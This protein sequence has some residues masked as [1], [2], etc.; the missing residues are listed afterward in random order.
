MSE[1]EVRF[2]LLGS[3]P[4]ADSVF[5]GE[6][7]QASVRQ[8]VRALNVS[9]RP[10]FDVMFLRDAPKMGRISFSHDEVVSLE[11]QNY[12]YHV[13]DLEV[14]CDASYVA[15]GVVVSNCRSSSTPVL[16]SYRELGIPIDEISASTRASMDGEVPAETTYSEWIAKQSAARQDEV[17]GPTRGKLFR[18]GDLAIDRFTNDKGVFLTLDELRA[19]DAKAFERSGL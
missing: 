19:R 6:V 16:K 12:K 15:S 18:Q 3:G 8:P 4:D 5:L 10:S 17:L 1:P 14:Q 9:E 13:F 2:S 7:R 11:L